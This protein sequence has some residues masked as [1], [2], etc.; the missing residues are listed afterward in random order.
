M[1]K[2]TD[3]WLRVRGPQLRRWTACLDG[4][5]IWRGEPR[6]TPEADVCVTVLEWG[7]SVTLVLI[8]AFPFLNNHKEVMRISMHA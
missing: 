8:K 2:R 4:Y 1:S 7:V 3:F 5:S 6:G